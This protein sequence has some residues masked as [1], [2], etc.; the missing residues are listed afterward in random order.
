MQKFIKDW[1]N[2]ALIVAAILI[3][4]LIIFTKTGGERNNSTIVR[5]GTKNLTVADLNT[6]MQK[7][8]GEQMIK[9][10]VS[11][12]L[13]Q[14]YADMNNVTANDREID[15]LINQSKRNAEQ[16]GKSL[17]DDLKANGLTMD[18]FR[19][20]ARYTVLCAKLVVPGTEIAKVMQEIVKT[21]DTSLTYPQSYRIRTLYYSNEEFA[22][23][24]LD[25]VQGIK[26]DEAG[27]QQLA[28]VAGSA[29]N[30]STAMNIVRFIPE[31]DKDTLDVELLAALK[32]LKPNMWSEPTKLHISSKNPP[33]DDKEAEA[34]KSYRRII[35]LVEVVPEEKPTLENRNIIIAMDIIQQKQDY[36]QKF[37]QIEAEAR[38]KIDVTFLNNSYPVAA[39]FFDDLYKQNQPIPGADSLGGSA[40]N[41]TPGPLPAPNAIP[42][43]P[44]AGK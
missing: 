32:D 27:K 23:Q 20:Q 44:G 36:Y 4:V 6:L 17:D 2:S 14:T 15:Q 9:Q 1:R 16:Q 34:M 41:V 19:E 3:I 43:P 29:L 8:Y 40:L 22:K 31:G 33:K 5:V 37:N 39:K 25:T 42:T 38:Q 30:A 13:I 21:N 18:A 24:A 11:D 35:Q 10:T 7:R 28:Q 12:M 26:D